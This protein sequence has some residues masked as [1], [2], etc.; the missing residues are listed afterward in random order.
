MD[1]KFVANTSSKYVNA[2]SQI[3]AAKILDILWARFV[4][5]GYALVIATILCPAAEAHFG[6]DEV[7]VV[8]FGFFSSNQ[9]HGTRYRNDIYV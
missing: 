7:T 8:E 5:F 4:L 9:D 6:Y 2:K 1:K 3:T